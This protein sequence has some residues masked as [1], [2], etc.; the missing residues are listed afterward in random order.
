MHFDGKQM[1]ARRR[2][3]ALTREAV[4]IGVGRGYQSIVDYEL[5]RTQPP[6][7]VA[8]AIAELLG[9]ELTDLIARD[10]EAVAA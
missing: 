2:R 5:G 9:L 4:G 6:L 1:A 10:R 8:V 7:K 3:L